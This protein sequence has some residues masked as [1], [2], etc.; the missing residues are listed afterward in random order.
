MGGGRS[1][2][3]TSV[4][5]V[6]L[7]VLVSLGGPSAA[8]AADRDGGSEPEVTLIRVYDSDARGV[9]YEVCRGKFD[10]PVTDPLNPAYCQGKPEYWTQRQWQDFNSGRAEKPADQQPGKGKQPGQSG[11][12][13][14]AVG[15]GPATA[16]STVPY[17]GS[18]DPTSV[19][20]VS[21]PLCGEP[22]KLSSQQLRNCRSSRSPE[23]PYPVGNYGWDIHI[24]EGGF[25]T[26]LLAPTVSF[27]LQFLSVFWLALLLALKGCLIVLGFA[28]SL[29]PFTDNRMLGEISQGLTRFYNNFTDPWLTALIV[30]LGVWGLYN[31]IIR[32]RAGETLGGSLA[33]LVMMLIAMWMIH[34]PGDS[35]GRLAAIINKTS[36][37]AVAAPNSGRVSQ[38]VRSYGDAMGEV[39]NQMTAVPFCALNFSDVAWCLKSKPSKEAIEA[40]RDGLSEDEPLTQAL[41]EDLPEDDEAATRVLNRRMNVV[42]GGATTIS[43]LYLR[44]SP[45]SGPRDA[46]W[47]YYNGEG[48]DHVGLPLHI[49]PQINVGGGTEGVAPDKVSMQG[50]SGLLPRMVLLVVFFLGLLGGLLLLLWIAMKLIM[51]SASAFVLVLMAPLAMFLPAFGTAGRAAF[52]K[53]GTSLLGAVVAKLIFSALLGV[54]LLGSSILGSGVGGSSPALGLIATMSFWWAVFLNRERYLA[55]LQ[56]DPVRDQG[57]SFY[58]TMAGGY[59]GYRVARAAKNAIGRRRDASREQSSQRRDEQVRAGREAGD[60]ELGRQAQQ[61]LDVA[62]ANA[63]GRE[64]LY[65]KAKQDAA[66]LRADPEVQALRREGSELE[67]EVRERAEGKSRQLQQ[68][69][70]QIDAGR[71]GSMADRQLLRRVGANEAAGLPRYGSREIEGAKEAIRRESSLPDDAPEHHWRAEA[72]GKDP[73]SSAGRVVIGETLEQSRA[74]VGATS[75][76]RLAQVDLHRLRGVSGGRR[77]PPQG[78]SSAGGSARP[79]GGD[80]MPRRRSRARDGLSR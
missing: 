77:R 45:G 79:E 5:F 33:A 44:F 48:D 55:L 19:L 2:C 75:A 42:F 29:S 52:T 23:A 37:A 66:A 12:P 67:P 31:G 7:L 62:T 17:G 53:W 59:V 64:S 46:L 39:W 78:P 32:R 34:A 40:A 15:Q 80:H 27:F 58:R 10:P 76:S 61:R 25:I 74:A 54:V 18:L 26:S 1:R 73:K 69:E 24:E 11:P 68:L 6:A 13:K 8:P 70:G 22:R 35:V 43:S 72:A 63:K 4:L 14:V 30:I 21:N 57:T 3:S 56:I 38:P 60:Q 20:G 28:F 16:E 51:A 36:L 47:K 41:V 49:G 9:V 50:R 65:A 71:S